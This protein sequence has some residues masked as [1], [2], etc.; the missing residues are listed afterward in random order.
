MSRKTS[1]TAPIRCLGS[2]TR[3]FEVG[4]RE[5]RIAIAATHTA[6][7]EFRRRI[8]IEGATTRCDSVWGVKTTSMASDDGSRGYIRPFAQSRRGVFLAV[9][10]PLAIVVV[11]YNG[12][13]TTFRHANLAHVHHA[14]G[15]VHFAT[16]SMPEGGFPTGTLDGEERSV[17]APGLLA[18]AGVASA[19]DLVRHVAE[20]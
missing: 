15:P 19:A 9:I 17:A 7:C 13:K 11:A 3:H 1:K 16:G 20:L 8:V 18:A 5:K 2:V 12:R 6:V 10:A 4:H 14:I